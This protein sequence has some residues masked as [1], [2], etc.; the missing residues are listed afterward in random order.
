MTPLAHL[1]VCAG[2]VFNVVVGIFVGVFVF[3]YAVLHTIATAL[4]VYLLMLIA[5]RYACHC[6]I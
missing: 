2:H 3:D 4:V 6:D 1:Y 5:P